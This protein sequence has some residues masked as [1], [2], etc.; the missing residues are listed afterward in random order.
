MTISLFG[1][2]PEGN[3]SKS[4]LLKDTYDKN[5]TGINYLFH[6]SRTLSLQTV[7]ERF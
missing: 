2:F 4:L 1:Y 7:I 6:T 3:S 5:T